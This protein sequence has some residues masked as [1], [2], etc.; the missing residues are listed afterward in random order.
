MAAIVAATVASDVR[1][2]GHDLDQRHEVR[3]VERVRDDDPLGVAAGVLEG[4]G[5]EA[6]R[7]AGQHDVGRG[8][9]VERGEQRPLDVEPL[10]AGLD[11][12]VGGGRGGRRRRCAPSAGR[13]RRRRCR[14]RGRRG[15]RRRPPAAGSRRPGRGRRRAPSARAPARAPPSSRRWRRPRRRPAWPARS[16][17]RH[18]GP[19]SSTN[20]SSDGRVGERVRGWP[21]S[22]PACPAG[23]ASPAAR[24][25]CR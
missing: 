4:A 6:G 25:S 3:R 14:A 1:A 9:L 8:R 11:H 18:L 7:A 13:A 15:G 24:A 12:Q 23:S 21:P 19:A 20:G 22:R 17:R 2:A 5:P 16:S 10:G